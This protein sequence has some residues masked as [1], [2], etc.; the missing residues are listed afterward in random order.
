M[1]ELS[2]WGPQWTQRSHTYISLYNASKFILTSMAARCQ[3][4]FRA[5]SNCWSVPSTKAKYS[6]T[7]GSGA[8]AL[9]NLATIRSTGR[10]VFSFLAPNQFWKVICLLEEGTL[11]STYSFNTYLLKNTTQVGNVNR[12]QHYFKI[13]IVFFFTLV[14]MRSAISFHA[15]SEALEFIAIQWNRRLCTFSWLKSCWGDKALLG[16]D[17]QLVEQSSDKVEETV[18]E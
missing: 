3:A 15:L 8:L 5:S 17:A 10:R 16:G 9:Y 12:C 7:T 2:D 1:T 6:V 18:P 14:R 4:S 13:K 11:Y